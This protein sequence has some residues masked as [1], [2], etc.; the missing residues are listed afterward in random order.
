MLPLA[1]THSMITDDCDRLLKERFFASV[2]VCV[3]YDYTYT[4]L[5]TL[6]QIIPIPVE[7]HTFEVLYTV[8]YK[9]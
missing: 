5:Q 8:I 4:L 6:L 2:V 7:F 3:H 9:R 1:S